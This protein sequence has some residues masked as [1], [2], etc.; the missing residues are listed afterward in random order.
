[1]TKENK[2]KL[3]VFILLA[4]F[5][6]SLVYHYIIG[7]YFHKGMPLN[8]FLF[9]T[10]DQFMDFVNVYISKLSVYF[11]FGNL[12]INIFCLIKPMNFSLLLFL[13]SSII[14]IFYYFWKNLQGDSTITTITNTLVFSLFSFP[15]LFLL[16]R[17]NF[18]SFV[19]IFLILF[20][21][22]YQ[23]GKFNYAII[24][25]SFAIA[26]KLFPAVFIILL[27]SDKK[28]KH[29]LWTV[30]LVIGLTVGS[31]LILYGS[32]TQY[33]HQLVNNTDFY[34]NNYVIG[35]GGF[36]FGNSLFGLIKC[37]IY[38]LHLGAGIPFLLKPYSLLVLFLAGSISLYT[39]FIETQFWKQIALL[40]FMMNL[41]PHVS[42]DY[43]LVYLFIPL[44]LFINSKIDNSQT[45]F[46][47]KKRF[48]DDDNK[49]DY[50][51]VILF[52]LLLIPK[53]YR[54]FSNLYD[55]VYLDPIL[56]IS[57]SYLIIRSG[58]SK[59]DFRKKEILK[60]IKKVSFYII[61]FSIVFSIVG[62]VFLFTSTG[63]KFVE[64]KLTAK[65]SNR[66]NTHVQFSAFK[67]T[68]KEVNINLEMDSIARI[69]FYLS[70]QN[71]SLNGNYKINVIDANKISKRFGAKFGFLTSGKISGSGINNIKMDGVTNIFQGSGKYQIDLQN[72]HIS[73]INFDLNGIQVGGVL[74]AINKGGGIVGT[75]NL[76]GDVLIENLRP[77][78]GTVRFSA[79][80][81]VLE[82]SSS[83]LKLLGL[84]LLNNT[85]VR[86]KTETT[87]N[88]KEAVS[89]I[90]INSGIAQITMLDNRIDLK[91]RGLNSD[92][93][94]EIS[95]LK[96]IVISDSS[97][98]GFINNQL[99]NLKKLKSILTEKYQ[100][101]VLIEGR[102]TKNNK[103]EM[104]G[105]LIDFIDNMISKRNFKSRSSSF[106]LVNNIV[107]VNDSIYKN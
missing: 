63:N 35:D 45:E 89:K 34:T 83:F 32:I 76:S 95:N 6:L 60:K 12:I 33:F 38:S 65:L 79:D 100:G 24:P 56:M 58:I 37:A 62:I 2:T 30:L 55:G 13:L 69:N 31:S 91:S 48:L 103:I 21:Y 49:L 64:N 23:K 54:L 19:F 107:Y 105:I 106:R 47:S 70:Y 40:V 18:E 90:N 51:Y 61:I 73:K 15:I 104:N 59:V 85:N 36:D 3:L 7:N 101:E 86:A 42:A 92:Y 77:T 88:G 9:S 4:G 14:P 72:R 53:N 74:A 11:P 94:I 87:F 41:L 44:F 99:P 10:N 5:I 96:D 16:D 84:S 20:V 80:S 75:A 71:D 50:L 17:A 81:I 1:M 57:I 97:K 39:I 52:G 28:Y 8:T 78:F 102:L 27:F 43:K 29:I 46:V 98:V 66:F 67:F 25:L 93:L 26:M 82:K 68:T 22:L